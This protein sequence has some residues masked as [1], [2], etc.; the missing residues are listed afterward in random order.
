M[1][2]PPMDAAAREADLRRR[3]RREIKILRVKAAAL[4]KPS[5]WDS[6]KMRS[7]FEDL[8]VDGAFDY[9]PEKLKDPKVIYFDPVR[10]EVVPRPSPL[11]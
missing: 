10:G 11:R 9:P 2:V 8:F 4:G 1:T 6:A 7:A 3:V 5:P